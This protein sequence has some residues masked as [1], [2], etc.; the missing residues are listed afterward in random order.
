MKA[1][2]V[3]KGNHQQGTRQQQQETR[4]KTETGTLHTLQKHRIYFNLATALNSCD[5]SQDG[6]ECQKG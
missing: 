4:R 3:R 5:A 1:E 6:F 2:I